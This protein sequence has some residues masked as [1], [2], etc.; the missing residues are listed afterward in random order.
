MKIN[1]FKYFLL[2][3]GILILAIIYLS[4]IGIESEKTIEVDISSP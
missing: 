3:L 2:F 1:I 4:V